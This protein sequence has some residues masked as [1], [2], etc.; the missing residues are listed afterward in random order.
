MSQ[1]CLSIAD[2]VGP[3]SDPGFDSG[4]V[5]RC[6][7]YWS[8]PVHELP[9]QILATLLRQR[10]AISLVEPEA[11][12][13]GNTNIADGSELYEGELAEA[14]RAIQERGSRESK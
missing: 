14:L 4:L 6:E 12:R 11:A 1:R 2:V 7:Q 10:I 3:W 8:V 9:D 5:R 13:R